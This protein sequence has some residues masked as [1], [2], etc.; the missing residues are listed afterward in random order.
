MKET[1]FYKSEGEV[2]N[3]QFIEEYSGMK[4]RAVVTTCMKLDDGQYG[5]MVFRADYYTRGEGE[6]QYF[7][8]NLYTV[9]NYHTYGGLPEGFDSIQKA[10]SDFEGVMPST[11]YNALGALIETGPANVGGQ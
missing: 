6:M 11:I 1:G 9:W 3:Y 5:W 10:V 4:R 8:T 7:W 2:I